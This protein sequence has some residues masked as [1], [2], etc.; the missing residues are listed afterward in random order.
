MLA[1]LVSLLMDLVMMDMVDLAMII[2]NWEV[3]I[4][5]MWDTGGRNCSEKSSRV[6]KVLSQVQLK[7][8]E[9]ELRSRGEESSGA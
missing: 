6:R 2:S 8:L 1:D 9:C 5:S 3:C 7:S 4:K